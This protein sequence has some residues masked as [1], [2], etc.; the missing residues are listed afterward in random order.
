LEKR[1][2]KWLSSPAVAG[3]EAQVVQHLPSKHEALSSN[4][5]FDKKKKK[6]KKKARFLG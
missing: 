3:G 2:W 6:K 4:P 5:S 1:R